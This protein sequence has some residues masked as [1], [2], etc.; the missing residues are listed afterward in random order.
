M[1][2][3]VKQVIDSMAV[4][5]KD[6]ESLLFASMETLQ[7]MIDPR[8]FKAPNGQPLADHHRS[9]MVY[10]FKND[11]DTPKISA[12]NHSIGIAAQQLKIAAGAVGV[13]E[14]RNAKQSTSVRY[15]LLC[16]AY[17][18]RDAMFVNR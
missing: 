13:D 12:Q 6:V 14:F 11:P 4:I 16:C 9:S 17:A 8:V 5:C 18:D 7:N 2:C 3:K 15:Y 1:W 10:L